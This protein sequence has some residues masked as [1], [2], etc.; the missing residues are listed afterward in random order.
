MARVVGDI[1]VMVGADITA[2]QRAM[3]QGTGSVR[4]FERGFGQSAA[5]VARAAAGIGAA[6]AAAA[7]AVAVMAANAANAG[8]QISR[9]AQVSNTSTTEFQRLA[10]ASATV[11]IEQDKLADIL[12][13][14]N[15]RVGDFIATGGGPMADFFENIAPQV[16]VTADQFARLG[17]PEALQLYVT[18]L[19]KAGVT[20]AEMTF[21]LE[22][23]ASDLTMLLP[24]L[25]N[26]GAEMRAI[27]DEAERA[28]RILSEDA[29]EGAVELNREM[30]ELGR[31]ISTKLNSA[32]LDNKSALLS[33]VSFISE[34][35]I[36]AIGGLIDAINS[37]FEA[38]G[39][40]LERG[41]TGSS[42]R[43][44]GRGNPPAGGGVSLP[45]GTRP[46][47][48]DEMS[49]SEKLR[50]NRTGAIPERFSGTDSNGDGALDL[51]EI[52]LPPGPGMTY[53]PESAPAF[54]LPPVPPAEGG[55]SD[56]GGGGG[57]SGLSR[58]DF[59]ILRQ[60]FATEYEIMAEEY[61]RQQALLSEYHAAG[62][63]SETEYKE[64]ML[65]LEEDYGARKRRAVMDDLSGL[66]SLMQAENE[67]LFKIGKAAALAQAIINGEE[68]ATAAWKRGMEAGGPVVAA[69]YTAASL[70]RTGVSIQNI[71]NA[72]IGGGGGGASSGGGAAAAPAVAAAPMEVNL[73]T[74][75]SGDFIRRGDL[76]DLLN[77]LQDEA[78][79]RGLRI[80][81]A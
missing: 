51:G 57:G 16:G 36:P 56:G 2:L 8:A 70:A 64:A 40:A 25:R 21:Y 48:Y 53:A 27:G 30:D 67:N 31:T 55:G 39:E 38:Y 71:R 22:A 1:S 59:D 5:R 78:G 46:E 34:T 73:R 32:I 28:G 65:R 63:A 81:Y 62:I 17:G 68:A 66:T 80:T 24:L 19:E 61:E 18:S 20:Q 77:Q 4:G 43:R 79:D 15:D 11:G 42:A 14:V 69:A 35:A 26:G 54:S 74:V 9:L 3:R 44:D 49:R 10:A 37:S 12:K 52:T 33:L 13:D 60:R 7:G 72:S 45:G 23:M 76:G 29:I 75:G 41:T 50:Y 47:F 6:A 58:D